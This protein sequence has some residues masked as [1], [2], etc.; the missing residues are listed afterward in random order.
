[1]SGKLNCSTL[2][3]GL[4]SLPRMNISL[5]MLAVFCLKV[6]LE[7]LNGRGEGLCSGID[8]SIN[9][10]PP[11]P[12]WTSHEED[13]MV[14]SVMERREEEERGK[15]IT[16]PFVD[17][18]E[19]QEV[20]EELVMEREERMAESAENREGSDEVEIREEKEDEVSVTEVIVSSVF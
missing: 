11:L 20:K 7:K 6:R 3:S 17:L 19:E 8:A 13:E 4:K 14:V 1:M 5:P 2:S 10:N 12:F 16:P 15:N 18:E 9:R